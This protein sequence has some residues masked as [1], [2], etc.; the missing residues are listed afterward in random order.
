MKD[1]VHYSA[2]DFAEDD[3]FRQWVNAPSPETDLFW[4]NWMEKHPERSSVIHDARAM[5]T[6]MPPR[7]VLTAVEKDEL[8][9]KIREHTVQEK[10]P[11][12]LVALSRPEKKGW[13]RGIA[14]A[15]ALL[16][17][18][19]ASYYWLKRQSYGQEIATLYGE[20]RRI[21]LPDGSS[22]TLNA[23][24]T[25]HFDKDISGQK[26]R[27]VWLDGEAFFSVMHTSTNQQFVVHTP[28]LD[29]EVLGTE[30]N[31]MKR[32]D[33]VKV[34]LST[35]KIKLHIKKSGISGQKELYM[36]PGDLVELYTGQPL[37]MKKKVNASSYCAWT[38]NR[39]VFEDTPMKEITEQLQNIYG[40]KIVV[41][42][43]SIM[44]EK[45]TG[46]I[47]TGNEDDLLDALSKAMDLRFIKRKDTVTIT[48]NY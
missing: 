19:A 17:L 27:Q 4:N 25:I 5:I 32:K 33:H 37:S 10:A 45:L 43:P 2:G 34:L 36:K 40:W 11:A 42:D 28:E 44:Q 38:Q 3:A 12:R 31:V 46:E 14:A 22:V 26:V 35:G 13:L 16:L 6:A 21:R 29:I 41:N 15:V 47:G 30:F 24:S 1:Y 20:M 18:V 8:W 48:R 9:Q 7:P 39:L 23:N